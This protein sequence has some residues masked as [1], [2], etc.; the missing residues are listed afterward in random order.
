MP[1]AQWRPLSSALQSERRRSGHVAAL[2]S[3]RS[4]RLHPVPLPESS[5]RTL[6]TSPRPGILLVEMFSGVG[7]AM[8]V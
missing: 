5:R 2:S 7:R 4:P 8:T 6:R 3:S 1:A